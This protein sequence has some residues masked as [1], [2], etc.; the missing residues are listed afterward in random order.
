MQNVRIVIVT[1]LSGSGKSTALRALEDIG[2]FCVDNLPV[3]LLPKFLEMQTEAGSEISKV[4]FVMDIRERSFLDRYMETFEQLKAKGYRVEI[5]FLDA[6]NEALL[7]RFSETRRAHPLCEKGT[8]ME[9]IT[10]ERERLSKLKKMAD[11]VIDTSSFNVHQLKDVI[12][13]YFMTSPADK[14]LVINLTS[15]GYRYG[16]P[17]DADVVLDVRFLP[18]PYFVE[19]LKHVDGNDPKVEEYVTGWNESVTFLQELFKLMEFLIPLYEKEGKS[20]LNI[21]LGCTGGKHRSVVMANKLRGF[22]SVRNFLV[23]VQHRDI[24]RS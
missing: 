3:V 22:F 24:Y 9:G 5:V 2:F 14:R 4:A 20:S 1:G 7:R 6:S 10:L 16:L 11:K 19:D 18:N 21:A 15:F 23:N 8:V 17:P 13:R 12:H